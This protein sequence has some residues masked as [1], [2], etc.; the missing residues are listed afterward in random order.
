MIRWR[1]LQVVP[2]LYVSPYCTGLN[3]NEARLLWRALVADLDRVRQPSPPWTMPT[4]FAAHP[5]VVIAPAFFRSTL[6][7]STSHVVPS[8]GMGWVGAWVGEVR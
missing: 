2:K 1:R 8:N 3:L 5:G 7:D 6:L 4:A